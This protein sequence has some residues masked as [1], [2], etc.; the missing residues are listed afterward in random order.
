MGER[1]LLAAGAALACLV[2]A[3]GV[4]ADAVSSIHDLVLD[5]ARVG[6]GYST[7][8]EG[9]AWSRHTRRALSRVVR[10]IE[11]CAAERRVPIDRRPATIRGEA[12]FGRAVRASRVTITATTFPEAI[13]PCVVDAVRLA[14]L[15]SSPPFDLQVAF[16]YAARR[17]R[18]RPPPA[19]PLGELGL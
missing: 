11:S 18:S 6:P 8:G 12:V 9:I 2:L 19:D 3:T 4:R 17:R 14:E 10:T 1:S 15:P 13:T 7:E 16:V 5:T